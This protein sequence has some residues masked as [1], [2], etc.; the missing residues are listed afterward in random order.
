MK[1][2]YDQDDEKPR[3]QESHRSAQMFGMLLGLAAIGLIVIILV[4]IVRHA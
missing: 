3:E 4:D 1:K 2:I